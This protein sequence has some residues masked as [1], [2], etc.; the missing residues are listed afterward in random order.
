MVPV[1][2][3]KKACSMNESFISDGKNPFKNYAKNK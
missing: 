1:R 3:L 2:H